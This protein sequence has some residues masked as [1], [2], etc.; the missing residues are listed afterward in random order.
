MEEV[1]NYIVNNYQLN[2]CEYI[3][4]DENDYENPEILLNEAVEILKSNFNDN[5]EITATNIYDNR[6][7]VSIKFSYKG[8]LGELS[9]YCC[10]HGNDYWRIDFINH[11]MVQFDE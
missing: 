2:S 5:I 4:Q 6:T 9:S 8:I 10:E 3:E 7:S 11:D 1:I